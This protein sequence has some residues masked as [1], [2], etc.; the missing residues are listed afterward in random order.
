MT[1]VFQSILNMKAGNN[2]IVNATEVAFEI[3]ASFSK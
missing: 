2:L 3:L 1:T